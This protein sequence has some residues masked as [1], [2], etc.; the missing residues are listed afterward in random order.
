MPY[1]LLTLF[2]FI[3]PLQVNAAS[4]PL[5]KSRHV[6]VLDE[7]GEVI[8][9]KKA[10]RTTPIASI[11]KLMTA[12]VVLDAKQNMKQVLSIT[13][14][15]RDTLKKTGS[16]LKFGAR[17]TRKEMLRLA[18]SASE[19]RAAH[20]LARNYPGGVKG[21]VR[22]MN[23][24]AKALGMS[25]TRFRGPTGL[26]PG[27]ISTARDLAVMVKA[28]MKYSFIRKAST[29]KKVVVRPFRK[30]KRMEF[31]ITNRLLRNSDKKWDIRLSKTGYINEAGRCL[32]M[33]AKTAGKM[34][35]IVLLNAKNKLT[36]YKDSNRIRKWLLGNDNDQ[37]AWHELEE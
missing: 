16:R 35:T 30:G 23:K 33:R 21:F 9:S 27:N 2:M 18:L 26:N 15:D 29:T 36:P 6:L 10:D 19:N 31:K 1:I 28:G 22:A 24:K 3:I 5:L 14:R 12:M 25:K 13:K 8:V 17:L 7:K 37:L 4:G 34:L 32:V 20:A 11:T